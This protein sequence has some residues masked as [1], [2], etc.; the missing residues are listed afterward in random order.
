MNQTE[1]KKKAILEVTSKL[2]RERLIS[3][4][5][6]DEIA[7]LAHV[8]KVTIF[9][10][11]ESKNSLMNLVIRRELDFMVQEIQKIIEHDTDFRETFRQ[12]SQFKIKQVHLMTD[13]F[14]QNMM[15]QY[16]T[17]PSFFDTDTRQLQHLVYQKLFSKGRAEEEISSEYTDE[18]LILFIDIMSEGMK[19][20]PVERA[21]K[22]PEILTEMFLNALKKAD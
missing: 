6:M 22:R 16:A 9:K 10:Y 20:I 17:E 13:S 12:V 19:T 18:D 14:L 7:E 2:L 8:S 4:I 21:L 5:S 1:K 3:D 15:K 11:Y